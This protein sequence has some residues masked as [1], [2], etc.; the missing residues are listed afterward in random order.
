MDFIVLLHEPEPNLIQ[1]R[2]E[3][4]GHRLAELGGTHL[5]RHEGYRAVEETDNVQGEQPRASACEP[6]SARLRKLCGLRTLNEAQKSFPFLL[7][8]TEVRAL[9]EAM[10]DGQLVETPYGLQP[11]GRE[12]GT[13]VRKVA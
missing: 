5:D 9:L 3:G 10:K 2:G 12:K 13:P 7:C 1:Y 6:R 4:Q 11:L 8:D